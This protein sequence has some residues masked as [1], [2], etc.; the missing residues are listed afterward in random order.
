MER[1]AISSTPMDFKVK[2]KNK[3][4]VIKQKGYFLKQ[5]IDKNK[6]GRLYHTKTKVHSQ[7][8]RSCMS[9]WIKHKSVTISLLY[10]MHKKVNTHMQLDLLKINGLEKKSLK[11][12]T[13][14]N[15]I[16]KIIF[17]AWPAVNRPKFQI[18]KS[19]SIVQSPVSLTIESLKHKK[20]KS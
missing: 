5:Q 10:Q 12:N 4:E 11:E 16:C 19:G 6:I 17:R 1:K 7:Q 8:K 20:Q 14:V 15:K 18:V 9:R 2:L 13:P 3:H